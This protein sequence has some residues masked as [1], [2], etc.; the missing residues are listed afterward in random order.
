VEEAGVGGS[1]LIPPQAD[2]LDAIEAKNLR[3]RVAKR[4][5][6]SWSRL[7]G[8]LRAGQVADLTT[9]LQGA[10]DAGISG[11]VSN[12]HTLVVGDSADGINKHK[13]VFLLQSVFHCRRY[14]SS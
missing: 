9:R 1:W 6:W 3:A 14:I 7:P 13:S 4:S 5:H 2:A 12:S 8:S 10:W 11:A